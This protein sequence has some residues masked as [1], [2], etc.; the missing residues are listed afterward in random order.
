M[1]EDI[2]LL[3][4]PVALNPYRRAL[5]LIKN[6]L[7]WDIQP[8][9]WD[10][11]R[12]LANWKDKY[13]GQKAVILCNGP[14]LL[15]VDF[16]RLEES[17]V[18]S[19]GLNKINLL[20]DKASFRPSAIVAVN[21]LVLEQ[22]AAFYNQT[23]IPLFLDSAALQVGIRNRSNVQYL[24]SANMRGEFARDCRWSVF[25][26]HTVTYVAMQL[27]FH[28][29]FTDVALVGCDHNFATK[30]AANKTVTSGDHDPNHFDPNY[31]A[32]GMKW[33]LP[34]LFESE[35]AYKL[36]G[37]V[38]EASNRRLV[39]ATVGGHL[40]LFRRVELAEFLAK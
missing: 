19:F 2:P 27:A 31:F 4:R 14:S 30:G 28:M 3:K 34:D 26:G 18:F 38:F 9:A 35:V 15:K 21:R 40:E 20:F 22:N 32:H 29:G 23:D 6:R 17:G 16:Q 1:N 8:A 36:A 33:Q 39:N 37:D 25:Q 13:S 7:T 11:R 5:S 24:H 12:K 10:S